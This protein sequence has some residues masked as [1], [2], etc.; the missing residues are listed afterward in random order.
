MA[1]LERLEA[2]RAAGGSISLVQVYTI[3]RR[4]A[5]PGLEPLAPSAIDAIVARA[6]A[7]GFAA[8]GYYGPG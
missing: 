4:T 5:V 8:E 2:V 3:A 7:S 6:R 1:W